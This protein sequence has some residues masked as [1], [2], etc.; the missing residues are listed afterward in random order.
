[1]A[2]KLAEDPKYAPM[3]VIA[4]AAHAAPAVMQA[5]AASG[6][7]G[8]VGKFDRAGLLTML[9]QILE[10]HDLNQHALESR[11]IGDAAA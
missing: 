11:I 4:L 9:G 2:R 10:S 3:P 1:L 6:M 5:A 7:C 8:A